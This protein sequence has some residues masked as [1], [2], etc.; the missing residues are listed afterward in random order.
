MGEIPQTTGRTR[1]SGQPKLFKLASVFLWALLMLAATS[2]TWAAAPVVDV[3]TASPQAVAPGGLVTLEVTAHDPDCSSTCPT[4]CGLYVRSDLTAWSAD[5]GV[6]VSE[7]NGTPGSPYTASAQWQAPVSEATF[8]LSVSVSDSGGTMCGGRQTTVATLQVQVTSNPSSPPVIDSLVGDPVSL[9]P[10]ETSQLTCAATDPDGDPVS[11]SWSTD[12]GALT[13]GAAGSAVFEAPS[14][15]VATVRCTATDPSG[16]ATTDGIVLS[17]SDVEPERLITSGLSSPHRLDVDSMGDLYVVDRGTRGITAIRLET[18]DLMYR[19]PINN[20]SSVAVD[21]QDRLLV[22]T[23]AGA[24][25]F[26]RAGNPVLDLGTGLGEVSDVAVDP[27]GRRYVTLYRRAGRVVVHDETGAVV[28]AFGSTGDGPGQ[29]M[30]PSGVAVMPNGHVVVADS[31]HGTVKIFDLDGDLVLEFGEPG[32]GAGQFVELD[33]VAVGSGGLIYTSDHYQD[34]VQTFNPDGTLREVIGTYGHGL[35]EFETAA[36]L[37][38]IEDVG[39]LL[40]ASVNSPGI[41]VFQLGSPAP[42]DWPAPEAEFSASTITFASQVVGTVSG[43]LGVIVTNNGNAPL[44]VHG[45]D[46]TGPFSPVN[47]CDL[48]NPGEWCSFEV[49]FTPT[50]PGPSQ[51]SMV[52]RSSAGG[53][54]YTVTLF[55]SG[56]VPAQVVISQT[57]LDFSSQ[58]I[59]TTSTARQVVLSNPGT[60]PLTISNVVAT[61]PFA[62]TSDCGTQI[63][64]GSWCTLEVDFAP[65][66]L[67]PAIGSVT[68]ESSDSGSPDTIGLSGEGI[69]LEITP[70]PGSI[71]FGFVAE[72]DVSHTEQIQVLN[73]GSGR[74]TVGTV[75][76][77]GA[78]PADFNLATDYC[79]NNPIDTGQTCWI[80]VTFSPGTTAESFAQLV[81]PTNDG[82]EFAVSLSGA[83][84]PLFADGFETGTTSAWV[85][86]QAKSV[87]VAPST[88]VFNEVDLGVEAGT[89]MV[90]V[91]NDGDEATYLGALWI[92]GDDALEFAIDSDSCSSTWLEPRQSC[93][94]GV[95]MLT[96]DEGN[97]S[98]ALVIP[99]AVAEKHQPAPVLL[100]GTV[101]W[102]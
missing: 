95:T 46:V 96:L 16:A 89:R 84:A 94:I 18:G 34:W 85:T 86:P 68:I 41:Q 98:A 20:A 13:P 49:V 48:I 42:V 93:T 70:D 56:F 60:V 79:S 10:G 64:G 27:V 88:V 14:P 72:G 43:P 62:V 102:P 59:D 39:K 23:A 21:W 45:V 12:F 40:V 38:A 19:I 17:V 83:V 100:T 82:L 35:G 25:V 75:M 6:F 53:E 33:D 99:A 52:I 8:T 87:Q 50:S 36:G 81:I 65:D 73:T 69:L 80:E 67:G 90:T 63:A 32:G 71:D 47:T 28:A 92:E 11:Y 58:G 76:F 78:N 26:D 3:F 77:A 31:G 91:R 30:G 55:G 1:I 5:G 97:F 44:G 54:P 51:G 24:A 9:Y 57:Q 22:G 29:L 66:T 101:R 37:V 7:N 2:G 61:A 4:G 15:G 74:V